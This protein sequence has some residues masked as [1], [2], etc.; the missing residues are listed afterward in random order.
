MILR[1]MNSAAPVVLFA[2]ARPQHLAHT[3]ESLR[4]DEVPLIY[5]F[6]DGPRT[7]DKAGD[8]AEVRRMLREISWAEV[9]LCE[10]QENFGL[11][12][13]ILTGVSAVLAEQDSIIV[14]EDDLI[15]VPGTYRYLCAAL[16]HYASEPS[17]MSVTGWTHP[18]VIPA[19]VGNKP[20]FDGRAE[21]LVWGTWARSWQGMEQNAMTLVRQCKANGIDIHRYG[22]DLIGMAEVELQQNIWAVRWLYLHILSGGLCFRP[23]HSLV[24]HIGFDKLATNASDGSEWSNPPLK[25]CPPLPDQWPVPQENPECARLW[26]AAYGAKPRPWLLKK[27]RSV[28]SKIKRKMF[29]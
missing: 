6:S 15:C 2:Y 3:L 19:S 28:A 20:Y 18:R 16:D 26:R 12:K 9:I 10:R 22:A 1:Q 11:G 8:V 4:A 13:S 29:S 24:E 14:F 17:V 23:P 25:P 27:A 7:P 21:C 5:A